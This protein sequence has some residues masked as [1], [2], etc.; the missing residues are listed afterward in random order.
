MEGI[1]M[2]EAYLFVVLCIVGILA[3]DFIA[4]ELDK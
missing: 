3:G 4:I 2:L 1:V